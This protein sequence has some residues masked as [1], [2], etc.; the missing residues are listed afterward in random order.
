MKERK[1]GRKKEKWKERKEG[2][3][4][5]RKKGKKRKKEKKRMFERIYLSTLYSAFI[6]IMKF[7]TSGQASIKF[8]RSVER[9]TCV[10][11]FNRTTLMK[12]KPTR[13][14]SASLTQNPPIRS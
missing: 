13:Y 14:I 4:K 7:T 11:N 8:C 10:V 6:S 1:K 9:S 5:E 12:I 2:R 3:N